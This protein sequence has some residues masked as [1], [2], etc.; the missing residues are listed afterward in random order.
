MLKACIQKELDEPSK[1][2]YSAAIMKLIPAKS[3]CVFAISVEFIS[4]R[5]VSFMRALL[6]LIVVA[7]SSS[8]LATF[9][10]WCA[11]RRLSNSLYG[12]STQFLRTYSTKKIAATT[13]SI[14][15]LY[16]TST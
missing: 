11:G 1:P 7:L 3:V 16:I 4:K 13:E 2:E 12:S 10:R 9:F 5:D 15:L 6:F 8:I 14:L